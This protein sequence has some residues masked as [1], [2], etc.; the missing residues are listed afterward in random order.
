MIRRKQTKPTGKFDHVAVLADSDNP[1]PVRGAG[2]HLPLHA[3]TKHGESFRAA[4]AH[5]LFLDPAGA[6]FP[7][8]ARCTL[9]LHCCIHQGISFS[10]K[11]K[12]PGAKAGNVAFSGAASL[13]TDEAKLRDVYL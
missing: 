2:V 10:V 6:M 1:L 4:A 11:R 12:K 13:L 5:E 8:P 9:H 3:L 7:G